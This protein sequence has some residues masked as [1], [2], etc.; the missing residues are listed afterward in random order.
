MKKLILL[1]VLAVSC[2]GNVFA[3][4]EEEVQ[5]PYLK[6][7]V[8]PTFEILCEDSNKIVST[9]DIPEGRPIIIM[10]F[11][12]D[13]DHCLSV[14]KKILEHKDEFK[15]TRIYMSSPMYLAQIN[16]F[17]KELELD[18]QKNIII[19]KDFNY[20][21]LKFYDLKS[22][23]FIAVYNGDKKL[24]EGFKGGFKFEDV[25]KALERAK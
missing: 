6:Y 4:E 13:C 14:T 17:A 2:V 9:Y 11:S 12:P 10:Y 15:K 24:V 21:V 23:P 25:L 18:K 5:P 8:L 16:E 3:Q 1:S 20:F 22:F 19:G 7:P